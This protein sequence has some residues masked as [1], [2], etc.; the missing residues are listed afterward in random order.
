MTRAE[1]IDGLTFSL[2]CQENHY[3]TSKEGQLFSVIFTYEPRCSVRSNS[4]ILSVW[5]PNCKCS[6]TK[7]YQLETTLTTL[8]QSKLTGSHSSLYAP[9]AD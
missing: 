8:E 7:Y 6:T 5:H 1:I 2:A 4:D 9:L 3:Y